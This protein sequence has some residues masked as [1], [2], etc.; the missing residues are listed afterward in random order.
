ME[1]EQL[2][3]KIRL[4]QVE[5]RWIIVWLGSVMGFR[6]G[7]VIMLYIAMLFIILLFGLFQKK[8][9]VYKLSF[10]NL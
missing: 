2:T 10:Y 8:K 7:P 3:Q 5:W 4:H 1:A 9:F 6:N